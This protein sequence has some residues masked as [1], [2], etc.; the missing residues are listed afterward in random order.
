MRTNLYRI[1]DVLLRAGGV[2]LLLAVVA[3]GL[4]IVVGLATGSSDG[5]DP[6][7]AAL[8]HYAPLLG[9]AALCPVALL[10]LGVAFRRRQNQTLA[11][12]NLLRQNAELQVAPLIAN[13]D[14]RR[15]DLERTVRFLNNRGLDHYVWD[16]ESD[17]IQDARLRAQQLHIEKCDEC[18]ASVSLRI[19]VA[20]TEVPR[21][22]FCHDP[23]SAESLDE[24]R[25]ET[26]ERLRAEHRPERERSTSG[27]TSPFSLALFVLLLFAFWPAGLVYAWFKWQARG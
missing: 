23:V 27:F 20:F 1:D 16:R 7:L 19:P 21:C 25:R 15:E 18:G 3:T 6:G 10:G 8:A 2:A 5:G 26:I 17:T 22:P 13:S 11:I 4:V 9:P 24:R 14:F 12:W